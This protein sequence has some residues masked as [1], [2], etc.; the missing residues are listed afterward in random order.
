MKDFNRI[1]QI[2][3]SLL[4]LPSGDFPEL[5]TQLFAAIL[6]DN[7]SE[8]V[9]N[10]TFSADEFLDEYNDGN[11]SE[12]NVKDVDDKFIKNLIIKIH[13]SFVITK[14]DLKNLAKQKGIKLKETDESLWHNFIFLV[15]ES[16]KKGEHPK[17]MDYARITRIINRRMNSPVVILLCTPGSKKVSLSLVERRANKVQKERDVIGKKV[18]MLYA[19]NCQKPHRADIELMKELNL[20]DLIK[21]QDL[22]DDNKYFDAIVQEW[23][24]EMSIEKLNKKFYIELSSWFEQAARDDTVKFPTKYFY[25]IVK[26]KKIL[27]KNR[28]VTKKEQLIRLVV[29]FI[30][31]WFIKEKGFIPSA[32]FERD[33]IF[34]KQNRD[35]DETSFLAGS[36]DP[37][38]DNYYRAVL[39]NLFFATLNTELT[40]KEEYQKRG[41]SKSASTDNF[42]SWCYKD[43]IKDPDMFTNLMKKIPFMNGGLFDC[44]DSVEVINKKKKEYRLDCFTNDPKQRR[45]L[46]VP[47]R[48]FFGTGGIIDIFNRYKFTLEENTPLDIDVALDPEL[49]GLTFENLLAYYNEETKEVA[50]KAT[51]SYYTP[52]HIVNFMVVQSMKEYFRGKFL[53]MPNE[54]V[55]ALLSYL[56]DPEGDIENEPSE[57]KKRA[58]VIA[59]NEL[60]ILDPAVGSGAFPMEILN[61]CVYLLDKLDPKNT[62]WRQHQIANIP[63][64][65]QLQEDKHTAGSILDKHAREEAKRIIQAKQKQIEDDFRKNSSRYSRKLYLIRNSIFGLDIQPIAVQ[66]A[67]LR[68][69]ISLASEQN[70]GDSFDDNYGINPLPNLETNFIAADALIHFEEIASSAG[71][72]LIDLNKAASVFNLS[73]A[74][75]KKYQDI[76]EIRNHVFSARSRPEKLLLHKKE[77]EGRMEL[78]N[79]I[80]EI[81]RP[82]DKSANEDQNSEKRDELFQLVDKWLAWDSAD[83]NLAAEWFDPSIMFYSIERFDIVVANPPYIQLQKEG[84][85]LGKKYGGQGYASFAKRGDIYTLFYE[86]GIN[87]LR[88]KGVL[89]YIT[90]N[91]W[92]RAEYGTNLRWFLADETSPVFIIDLGAEVFA[93]AT[94]DTNILLTTKSKSEEKSLLGITIGKE[95]KSKLESLGEILESATEIPLPEKGGKWIIIST[96]EQE[97]FSKIKQN[98]KPLDFHGVKIQAGVKTGK[99]EAFLLNNETKDK[100]ISEDKKSADLIKPVLRGKDIMRWQLK[101]RGNWLIATLPS[102]KIDIDKYPGVKKHLLSFFK[103]NLQLTKQPER[104]RSDVKWFETSSSANYFND[105]EKEKIIYSDIAT[106]GPQFYLDTNEHF[107]GVNTTFIM[108][109]DSIRYLIAF[110]NS[111]ITH[112]IFGKFFAGR[113]LGDSTKRYERTY[114]RKLPIP[115]TEGKKEE[116][117]FTDLVDKI[118][119]LNKRGGSP[120][121]VKSEIDLIQNNIDILVAKAYDLTQEEV[122]YLLDSFTPPP[123]PPPRKINDGSS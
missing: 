73:D 56:F 55:D 25:K 36:Y 32:L 41:F 68:F 4:S 43:E 123:P 57:E 63:E 7:F 108:T 77:R 31:V 74:C 71:D 34:A 53:N 38:L 26:G 29:R 118:V 114:I 66:V 87:L 110:L 101:N 9:Y 58:V 112:A 40:G 23:L 69:F 115:K 20:V 54:E 37:E 59:I 50:R 30:F 105:F 70:M 33:K 8:S 48:L 45:K 100:I 2:E 121:E 122:D 67:R 78:G 14:D 91:K 113:G 75:W 116:K 72:S 64:Y 83:Q 80:K 120:Y 103:E 96:M 61:I 39:Q 10:R 81:L 27:T 21:N 106:T 60:K 95:E 52:K 35:N 18:S 44:L 98:G 19:I 90:S 65:K 46:N 119:A 82:R 17:K 49:L 11:Y 13:L 5:G 88:D 51:G 16:K 22:P 104:S 1:T 109:G 102:R 86:R 84:G 76:Q 62:L 111:P 97:I 117:K 12:E 93:S 47:N 79:L 94:V 107:Y 42:N 28:E 6:G 85:K 3:K 15:A 92:M 89:T 24:R 99:N